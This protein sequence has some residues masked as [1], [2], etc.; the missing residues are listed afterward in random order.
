MSTVAAVA[1]VPSMV[2]YENISIGQSNVH[3]IYTYRDI[4]ELE[5]IRDR[6]SVGGSWLHEGAL[7]KR[8]LS[9]FIA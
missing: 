8:Y 9:H 7:A 1:R 5:K 2:R 4:V 6:I 3:S